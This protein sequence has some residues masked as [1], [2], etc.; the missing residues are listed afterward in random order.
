MVF[1]K[2]E[3]SMFGITQF[4][5]I[6]SDEK[7][8]NPRLLSAFS[9]ARTESVSHVVPAETRIYIKADVGRSAAAS[10]NAIELASCRQVVSFVPRSGEKYS[11]RQNLLAK[12]CSIDLIRIADQ[13]VPESIAFHPQKACAKNWLVD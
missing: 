10:G 11:L 13:K 1:E 6:V 3:G 5:S 2:P 12:S 7:C 9:P 8:S 4:N